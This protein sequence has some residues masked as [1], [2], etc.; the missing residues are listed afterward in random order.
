MKLHGNMVIE[1]TDEE[2]GGV[3]RIEEENMV[4]NA[5]NHILGLNPMGIFYNVAGQYDTHLQWNSEMLPICPNM[6]GGILLYSDALTED[7]DN[8]YPSTNRLPVAYASN[9]VN[10]TANVARGS[11]NLTESKALDNGYRFVWEF[12]PS[13]G[14]GTIAAVALTSAKGGKNAYGSGEASNTAFLQ[15]ME[16]RLE[17]QSEDELAELY[18]VVE[19]DFEHGLM[20][21]LTYQD[22]S[23]I[24]KKKRLPVFT[25]GLN[26]RLDDTTAT[27]LE[28]EVIHCNT[29][30]FLG[31]YTPYGDFL[32]G[33]DGY[34]YG[35]SNQANSS[36]NA[37]VYWIKIMKS[38][39]SMTEGVWTLSNVQMKTVGSFKVDTYV[40]RSIRGVIRNGYLYIEA[41]NDEGIYK[42]N[43]NNVAD[44][45]LIPLGFT[46]VNRPL[47]SSTGTCT[48]YLAMVN[49]LIIAY[50]YMV[51]P[52]DTVVQTAGNY[53]FNYI[54]TPLFQ[55]KEF[56]F[57]WGGNYGSDYRLAYLVTPY[58]ASINNLSTAVV[59]NTDKT[60]KITYELTE[61]GEVSE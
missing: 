55:Y 20:Y 45:T 9:D 31:S 16:T 32:D 33:H 59:K 13:Q 7:A 44:V 29:F 5:V 15:L 18:S 50:D 12:T 21:S 4:T 40:Q 8:I 39:Y 42:I 6:I 41:Y 3:E 14:N 1:L 52:D 22:Q 24:L 48:N 60:M 11:L 56:V 19:V 53:K 34:W 49:D 23:V 27:L 28:E 47:G 46:S 54:A 57:F 2:T 26:E 10:A 51:K 25:I 43:L 30:H 36:G 37:T 61:E 58:L 38:D 35:F 17:S